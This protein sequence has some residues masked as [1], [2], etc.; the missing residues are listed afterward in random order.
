[1]TEPEKPAAKDTLTTEL[2]A[3]RDEVAAINTR[4]RPSFRRLIGIQLLR[5]IAFGLGSVLGATLVVSI[6]IYSLSSIN[7]IPII[8][9]WASQI[10]DSIQKK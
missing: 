9:E 1:M 4:L 10:V 8:G 2:L 3:L 7:F 6:L 5:G